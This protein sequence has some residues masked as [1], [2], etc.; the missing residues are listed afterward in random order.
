M[1]PRIR[2]LWAGGR[3]PGATAAGGPPPLVGGGW[4]RQISLPNPVED[5]AES[6]DEG[7]QQRAEAEHGHHQDDPE[8]GREAG[9]DREV[10]TARFGQDL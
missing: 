7:D 1:S 6:R 5:V 3:A 8:V 9:V 4:V 2:S 10:P